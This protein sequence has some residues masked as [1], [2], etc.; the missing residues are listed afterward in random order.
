MAEGVEHCSA[1]V[2]GAPNA[3]DRGGCSGT[4]SLSGSGFAY[5]RG[6]DAVKGPRT[7]TVPASSARG[8]LP[9]VHPFAIL[10]G[11]VSSEPGRQLLARRP[12]FR[13]YG[14]QVVELA[15]DAGDHAG[16]V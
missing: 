16:D 8:R 6:R 7:L 9:P 12:R 13:W 5:W 4:S 1:P 14:L 15:A 3:R 11:G 10:G 2:P